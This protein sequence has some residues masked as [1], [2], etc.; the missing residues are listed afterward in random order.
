MCGIC[1]LVGVSDAGIVK[2]MCDAIA[3]RGPDD[4]GLYTGSEATLGARRLAIIDLSTSAHQPMSNEDGSLWL[5]F[6]GE[7]YNYRELRSELQR[8]GHVFRS[9]GDGE[10]LLHLYEE[11]GEACVQHLQG[12]YAFAIWDSLRRRLFIARDR[13]GIKPLYYAQKGNLFVFASEIKAMLASG[14]IAKEVDHQ[15]ISHFLSFGA[16]PAPRTILREVH[17]LLP[18]HWLRLQGGKLAV[19]RYW[20]VEFAEQPPQ[21]DER[22]WAKALLE[23]LRESVRSCMVSDVPLGAFLSGGI[24]SSAIVG[25]MSSLVSQ[26]VRTF[27]VRYDAGGAQYDESPYARMV[28]Q[29]FGTE[30]TEVV[31][32]EG[33][34]AERLDDIVW[35]MD[36]PSHD[37]L[38]SYFVSKAARTGVTVALSGLGGDELFAGYG[39]FKFAR[40]MERLRPFSSLLSPLTQSAVV[41]A[42]GLMP[43]SYRNH[44]LWQQVGKGLLARYPTTAR[45]YAVRLFYDEAE[46]RR[47]LQ[48]GLVNRNG[49]ETSLGLIEGLAQRVSGADTVNQISYLEMRSYM[50]DT[51]LRDADVMSMAHSLEVR[52]PYLDHRLVEFAAT[53]PPELKLRGAV[54]KYILKESL[55]EL[56]PNEILNRPKMGFSFPLAIW[57]RGNS[58]RHVV[59]SCL[60]REAVERRGF[61]RWREAA[62]VRDD[63]YRLSPE[64]PTVYRMC[65]RLWTIVVLELWCRRYLDS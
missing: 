26:P 15:A 23:Q 8:R 4:E 10:T 2:R 65:Q 20:D 58:L 31:V 61:F 36:Q 60:T 35:H 30:H 17:A 25:L 18:G 52:V 53:V 27:S 40:R 28:A 24:D 55:K 37:G 64:S 41:A 21:R 51:L 48:G 62:A 3:H 11:H 39:N 49:H 38:N 63:F 13:L 50:A 33:D 5:A 32:T 14:L 22:E 19:E 16:V 42:D 43:A 6:N 44:W 1:G 29:R 7:V 57:L 46:K 12:M 9:N 45:A 47:L 54:H 56:L 34:V 59:D